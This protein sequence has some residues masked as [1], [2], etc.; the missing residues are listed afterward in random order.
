MPD[1]TLE[2]S[3][4]FRDLGTLRGEIKMARANKK[5]DTLKINVHR[6]GS[7]V[8]LTMKLANLYI[9]GFKG[10]DKEY[11]V[12]EMCG[13]NYNNLGMPSKMRA[14]D[15]DRITK[16][17]NFSKGDKLDSE[18]I[19]FSAI[20]ISEAARF[21]GVSMHV[22]GLLSEAFVDISLAALNKKYFTMWSAHSDFVRSGKFV[23]GEQI[24]VDV[25]L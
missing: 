7:S 6:D 24:Q 19:T 11:S 14:D 16:L 3:H 15:L 9:V 2:K 4:Y 1:V 18:A 23:P 17:A 20:V 21:S 8:E 25:L 10:R 12:E 22:Q 13:E 5:L